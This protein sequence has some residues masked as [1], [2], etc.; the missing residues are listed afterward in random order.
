MGGMT[1]FD[2]ATAITAAGSGSYTADLD[3]G[4]L[5]GDAMN[6]G[7]LMAI[8]Q[9]AALA[10]SSHPHAVSSAFH[11]LR[12][13]GAGRTHVEATTLKAGRRITTLQVT[14]AQHGASLV[15]ATIACAEVDPAAVPEY[16]APSPSVPPLDQCHRYDPRTGQEPSTAFSE[17]V[18]QFYTPA[19]WDRLRGQGADQVPELA[20]YIQ[21]SE[22]DGG[23]TADPCGFLPLAV[24]ALP[25][26]VAALGSWRWSPTVELTWHMR[27]IPEPGP[28]MFLARAEVISDGWFDETVDLWDRKGTLVAQSRQLARSGR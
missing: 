1:R 26:V 24:D 7:Y 9:A 5:I 4:Y 23:P 20:G 16:Q 8:M 21:P 27:A 17:R 18:D 2:S 28:L 6:G 11:F 19:T 15:V 22:R 25:P 13:A 14:A 12:P 10:E 3:A